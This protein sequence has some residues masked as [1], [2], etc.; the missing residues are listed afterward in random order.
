MTRITLALILAALLGGV[1]VPGLLDLLPAWDYSQPEEDCS[2]GLSGCPAQPEPDVGCIFD[3]N[4][5]CTPGS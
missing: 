5:R 4:G 2:A 1:A 3:P